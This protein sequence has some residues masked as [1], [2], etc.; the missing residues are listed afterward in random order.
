MLASVVR[1]REFAVAVLLL[2]CCRGQQSER[3]GS[4][5]ISRMG[6]TKP[7]SNTNDGNS[8]GERRAREGLS[9]PVIDIKPLGTAQNLT[10]RFRSRDLGPGGVSVSVPLVRK[11]LIGKPEKISH[12]GAP[13]CLVRGNP[14]RLRE[15]HYGDVP[16]GFEKVGCGTLAPGHYVVS[17][18]GLGGFGAIIM[19]VDET[20]TLTAHPLDATS[21]PLWDGK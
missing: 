8:E 4:G 9:E 16:A 3:A 19:D 6:V 2:A 21:D 17:V 20:G 5:Q 15:W 7:S 11:I 1:Y 13:D 18:S 12:R 14:V 10:L